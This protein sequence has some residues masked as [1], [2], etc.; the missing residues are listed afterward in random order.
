V[1]SYGSHL[2]LEVLERFELVVADQGGQLVG[3]AQLDPDDGRLRALFVDDSCQGCG[4]G[5]LLLAELE[6]RAVRRRLPRIFGAMSL[7]AVPF[8]AQHGFRRC[9]GP[10]LLTGRVPV[11]VVPMEKVLAGGPAEITVW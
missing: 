4:I 3:A 8:Y 6:A 2:F 11:P 9:A 10:L 5:G 1:R 7:N